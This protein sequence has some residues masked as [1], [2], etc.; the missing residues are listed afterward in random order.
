[1]RQ[2]G[3]LPQ[4]AFL[5]KEEKWGPVKPHV[6]FFSWA[7]RLGVL[8]GAWGIPFL[9]PLFSGKG[10]RGRPWQIS[11][12]LVI[13]AEELRGG[14]ARKTGEVQET[15]SEDAKKL[16]CTTAPGWSWRGQ[17]GLWLLQTGLPSRE[18]RQHRW[19][20]SSPVPCH[21][22]FP[23]PP[24]W[25]IHS[26]AVYSLGALSAGAVLNQDSKLSPFPNHL[27]PPVS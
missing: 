22:S 5:W 14:K 11:F 13:A 21:W 27:I 6:T 3:L 1:M 12:R 18:G 16:R 9:R 10:Y 23:P 25:M 2:S 19:H 15:G 24:K 7:V 8:T 4:A 26:F 17:P 20:T